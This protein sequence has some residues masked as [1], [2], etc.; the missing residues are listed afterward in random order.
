MNTFQ[1]TSSLDDIYPDIENELCCKQTVNLNIIQKKYRQ[2]YP[3]TIHFIKCIHPPITQ[4][5]TMLSQ[6]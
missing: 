2:L 5:A 1:I 4:Y 3:S 6:Y